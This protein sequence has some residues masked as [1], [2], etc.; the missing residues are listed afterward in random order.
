MTLV[1]CRVL[2]ESDATLRLM[3]LIVLD[4]VGKPEQ[5]LRRASNASSAAWRS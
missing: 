5:S 3:S 1:S 2:S 4:N